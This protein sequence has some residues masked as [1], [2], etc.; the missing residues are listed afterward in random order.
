MDKAAALGFSLVMN[1]PFLDGNKRT[2]HAALETYLILNGFEIQADISEQERV[3]LQLAA[4]E[5][6][7]AAF[8]AWLRAHVQPWLER[9][10]LT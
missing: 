9:P 4:G 3:I 2:G 10:A 1:H 5:L 8:A 6:P 7:R